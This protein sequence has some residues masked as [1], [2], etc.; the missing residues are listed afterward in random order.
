MFGHDPA[1]LDEHNIINDLNDD[2]EAST[3]RLLDKEWRVASTPGDGLMAVL[4]A[5]SEALWPSDED[6]ELL[7]AVRQLTDDNILSAQTSEA[8]GWEKT[9]VN[10]LL[11]QHCQSY[12]MN[13]RSK[14]RHTTHLPPPPRWCEVQQ[15]WST[16]QYYATI[17]WRIADTMVNREV[18]STLSLA[19]LI[20]NRIPPWP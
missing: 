18:A 14:Q 5:D 16:L 9:K 2:F 6:N 12:V 19:L 1:H 13:R 7:S 11:S 10:S 17:Y 15:D 8:S 20:A 3:R 4:E